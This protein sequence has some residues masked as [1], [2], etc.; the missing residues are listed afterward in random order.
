MELRSFAPL[1]SSSNPFADEHAAQIAGPAAAAQLLPIGDTP[2]ARKVNKNTAPA[3]PSPAH[4][5]TGAPLVELN[6]SRN[7]PQRGPGA[8]SPPTGTILDLDAPLS[9]MMALDTRSQHGGEDEGPLTG[10]SALDPYGPRQSGWYSPA[11]PS[12][13]ASRHFGFMDNDP[14]ARDAAYDELMAGRSSYARSV[15]SIPESTM[16]RSESGHDGPDVE[17]PELPTP[18]A[19][20]QYAS[21]SG[22]DPLD[23]HMSSGTSMSSG[24]SVSMD[25]FNPSQLITPMTPGTA[26]RVQVG[27]S[28]GRAEVIRVPS[29][30]SKKGGVRSK[31]YNSAQVEPG[32]GVDLDD[33]AS[34][35]MSSEGHDPFD[36]ERA[37]PGQR[38]ARPA[39][40]ASATG[41]NLSRAFSGRTDATAGTGGR[42]LSTATT[43][44]FGIPI[45]DGSRYAQ[46][47]PLHSFIDPSGHDDRP[48]SWFDEDGQP[49][50]MDEEGHPV[51]QDRVA[52]MVAAN[53]QRYAVSRNQV[54]QSTASSI[55]GLSVFDGIPFHVQG[56]MPANAAEAV[57]AARARE[58]QQGQ[59]ARRLDGEEEQV[60]TAL[61]PP[62]SYG[63]TPS[64]EQSV[65]TAGTERGYTTSG[66]S[67]ANATAGTRPISGGSDYSQSSATTARALPVTGSSITVATGNSAMP[68]GATTGNQSNSTGT[69]GPSISSSQATR[70][71]A[72][73][74]TVS[75][76]LRQ[77]DEGGLDDYDFKM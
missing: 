60:R 1:R 41:S 45:L 58:A 39:V 48:L 40:P 28:G 64:T 71:T 72:A 74:R 66:L 57:A 68:T 24:S 43:A 67:T 50:E 54:R 25:Y 37:V 73:P 49:I 14:A 16:V 59:D 7:A 31:R 9:P 22:G 56:E 38:T 8:R 35:P 62:S 4:R 63:F 3:K 51:E 20:A 11:A 77:S 34:P 47:L 76:P 18:S 44:S 23:R 26:K 55:G 17:A 19:R 52:G 33:L 2:S 32:S 15:K 75:H 6:S 27:K 42:H 13:A 12:T 29:S 61:S 10:G 30:G 69:S 36:E 70:G 65:S 21:T 46:G 5:Q 53:G